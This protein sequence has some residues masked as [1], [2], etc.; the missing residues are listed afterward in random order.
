MKTEVTIYSCFFCL[1]IA[2]YALVRGAGSSA[3]SNPTLRPCSAK[4]GPVQFWRVVDSCNH[5]MFTSV[6][7][8]STQCSANQTSVLKERLQ[9]LKTSIRSFTTFAPTSCVRPPRAKREGKKAHFVRIRGLI[10]EPKPRVPA[11][12]RL[13]SLSRRCEQRQVQTASARTIT[14]SIS[15]VIDAVT[16]HGLATARQ[17][18]VIA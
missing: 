14:T 17:D 7:D 3:L 12:S 5:I 13:L 15:T 16:A 8:T 1:L 4:D 11:Q 18:R 10:G 6:R 9:G 2:L